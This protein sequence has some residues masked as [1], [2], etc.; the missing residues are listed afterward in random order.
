VGHRATLRT[1]AEALKARAAV[2]LLAV[3]HPRTPWYAKACGM[4]TLLYLL[5]PI[6]LI[7][8]FIPVLGQLDDLVLVPLGLWLTIRLIPGEVWQ[9]CEAEAA[10]RDQQ[11][12]RD[13]RG[14]FLVIGTWILLALLGVWLVRLLVPRD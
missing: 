12:M 14:L 4:V 2:L 1:R 8:D 5:A 6:D 7:P 3:S 11:P 13:R 9:E 10:R